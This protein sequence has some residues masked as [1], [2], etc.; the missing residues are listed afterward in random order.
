MIGDMLYDV[1]SSKRNYEEFVQLRGV[2][3]AQEKGEGE[4][5]SIDDVAQFSDRKVVHKVWAKAIRIT[6]EA[7]EDDLYQNYAQVASKELAKSLAH[8]KEINAAKLF[9]NATSTSTPYVDKFGKAFVS[10]GH[11]TGSGGTYSNITTSDLT[12]LAL[13][14]AD[15]QMQGWVGNDG[16]RIMVKTKQLLIPPQLRYKA[17]RI[18]RSDLRSGT[19]DNDTNA[20]KDMSLIPSILEWQFLEDTNNWFL[21]TDVDGLCHYHRMKPTS[22]YAMD[23]DTHDHKYSVRE[24]YSHDYNGDHRCVLGGIV[25]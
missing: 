11:Q 19:A 8:A 20:L 25:A 18:L 2:G 24:R 13:E 23:E 3:V 14:N 9:N 21:L 16:L 17:H 10:T 6:E 22:F 1:K 12:E 5:I 7:F 15:I 4:A